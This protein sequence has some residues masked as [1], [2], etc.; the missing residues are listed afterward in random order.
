MISVPGI[1]SA[2]RCY[3]TKHQEN[4]SRAE[5]LRIW[6]NPIVI[7]SGIKTFSILTALLEHSLSAMTMQTLDNP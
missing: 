1:S 5:R 3:E 4:I 7:E 2:T 6:G